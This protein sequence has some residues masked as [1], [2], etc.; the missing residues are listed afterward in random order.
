M[1]P[2]QEKLII[3][4]LASLTIISIL[5]VLF[6]TW[7]DNVYNNRQN[8]K[9]PKEK[10]PKAKNKKEGEEYPTLE[11]HE[12]EHVLTYYPSQSKVLRNTEGI[13]ITYLMAKVKPC[14]KPIQLA[15]VPTTV[16]TH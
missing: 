12:I 16:E 10:A 5:T 3:Y 15:W 11:L 1:Q 14:H 9:E 13:P 4:I 8:K 7:I 2:E 6:Q